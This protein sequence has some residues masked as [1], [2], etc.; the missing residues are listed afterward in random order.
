M[1]PTS[2]KSQRKGATPEANDLS[3]PQ[4]VWDGEMAPSQDIARTGMLGRLADD[5]GELT[6]YTLDVQAELIAGQTIV[7]DT[8]VG[9]VKESPANSL[10]GKPPFKAK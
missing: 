1:N 6:P 9:T 5:G 4:E 8:E 10:G 7:E 3:N 2:T